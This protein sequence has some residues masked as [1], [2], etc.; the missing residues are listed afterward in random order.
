MKK[1]F[2]F[3]CFFFISFSLLLPFV[4]VNAI[5]DGSLLKQITITP[6]VVNGIMYYRYEE[7]FSG[8]N[9]VTW[10]DSMP[11]LG[12]GVTL[13]YNNFS[14]DFYAQQSITGKDS[15][16]E[17]NEDFRQD[18]NADFSREDYTINVGY[19]MNELFGYKMN[20]I[21][22]F[23]AGYKESET[24]MSGPRKI[25]TVALDETRLYFDET[26]FKTSGYSIGGGYAWPIGESSLLGIKA[27]VGSLDGDYSSNQLSRIST[28]STN[29]TWL[30]LNWSSS[31]TKKVTYGFSLDAQ[32]YAM[33][34][35]ST[36]NPNITLRSIE[37]RIISVKALL[38][39]T[40][41]F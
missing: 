12:L 23:F 33:G 34:A 37:E 29:F 26:Q 7:E 10:R 6:R 21:L 38:S 8:S 28:A 15:Y 16:L 35:T 22:S 5:D 32:K 39:Y 30:S 41:D 13:G 36:D 20:G 3:I 9:N 1:S 25:T 4:G 40:F 24:D 14:V 18:Y 17:G 27:A 19:R 31:L 11:F 2:S